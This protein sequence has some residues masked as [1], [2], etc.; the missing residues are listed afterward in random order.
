MKAIV[1][2]LPKRGAQLQDMPIPVPGPREVLIQ[3]KATSICGTDL[4]NYEWS[5]WA[6]L[7]VRLPKIMGHEF[8]GEVVEVGADVAALHPGDFVSAESHIYCGVCFQCRTGRAEVCQN[9]RILGVDVHGC[10]AGFAMIPE[11]NAWKN[12]MSMT[13]DFACLQ[14]PMGNAVD[15]VLAEDV[16]GKTVAVFGCGPIGVLGVGIARASG[17]TLLVATDISDF[18]LDLARKL[19][20]THTFN[21]QRT[22]VVEEVQALTHGI[23]VDVVV[24]MSGNPA[25]LH[26]ALAILTPGGRASLLGLYG[27][28]ETLDLNR[29]IIFKGA[30]IYGITGRR[31]YSTWYKTQRFLESGLVDL[32]PLITHRLPLEE[33][34]SA[35][36]LMAEGNC[37]RV[38][39]YPGG[40]SPEAS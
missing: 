26:Q 14:E 3:V 32:S 2:A 40:N 20:A 30:R 31:F 29:E 11:I 12:S 7:R 23:G 39:M 1:K 36:A 33:Y 34:E 6:Q 24:E 10:F 19:G 35:M 17:A 22:D 28:P 9:V 37:G 16:A 5:E 25:A 18:R 38:I 15:A 8:A 21:P 4:N 13:L 27:N